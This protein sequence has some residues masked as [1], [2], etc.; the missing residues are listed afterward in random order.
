MEYQAKGPALTPAQMA[1]VRAELRAQR[2]ADG[3]RGVADLHTRISAAEHRYGYN[4]QHGRLA[5]VLLGAAGMLCVI[6]ATWRRRAGRRWRG[7]D[8]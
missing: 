7:N 3:L 6:A 2:H 5:G 1:L 4:R 8:D